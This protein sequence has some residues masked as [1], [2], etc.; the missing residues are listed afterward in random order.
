MSSRKYGS[1][2]E[3]LPDVQ[4]WSGGPPGSS[5]VIGRSSRMSGS[6]REA[7]RY[8]LEW[9]ADHPGRPRCQGVVGRRP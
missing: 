3:N 8:V 9:S 5:G 4:E 6:G 1:G 7:L 2:R